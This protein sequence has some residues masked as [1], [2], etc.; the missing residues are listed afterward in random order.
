MKLH[1][2]IVVSQSTAW[3]MLHLLRQLWAYDDKQNDDLL[4]VDA[5]YVRG[6]EGKNTNRGSCMV[7]VVP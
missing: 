2:D 5:A 3:F 4:V 1:S 6:K 7:D